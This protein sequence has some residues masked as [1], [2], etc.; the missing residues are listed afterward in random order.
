MKGTCL[1]RFIAPPQTNRPSLDYSTHTLWKYI[2]QFTKRARYR[3]SPFAV[4]F[5][6]DYDIEACSVTAGINVEISRD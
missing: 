5:C 3:Q 4:K 1:P 2:R 6:V